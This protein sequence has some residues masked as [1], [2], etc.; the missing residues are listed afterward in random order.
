MKKAKLLAPGTS[1]QGEHQ[2][3]KLFQGQSHMLLEQVVRESIKKA[4]LFQEQ[5]HMLLE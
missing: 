2:K 1:S 5:S 3:A 4:K